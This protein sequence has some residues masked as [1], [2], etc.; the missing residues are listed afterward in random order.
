MIKAVLFDLDGTLLDTSQGIQ[1]S[2]KYTLETLNLP[3]L[4]D[5]MMIKFVGPP[6]QSSLM[7][8]VG[9]SEE[10]AQCGANIF[11]DYYKTEALFEACVYPGII[12]LL[13]HLK[14]HNILVGI[15]T[16]KREDYAIDLLRHFG[17]TQFCDV[18]HG[19]D[20]YNKLTKKD[21]V[22][23]CIKDMCE[24]K[25]DVVLVGDTHFDAEGAQSAGVNFIA[26]TWGFG[27]SCGDVISE[28]PCKAIVNN[29]K[30]LEDIILCCR[31]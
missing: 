7:K 22:E 17:I 27:Y 3:L 12:E 28:Y 9:L 2:V 5:D 8:Y 21:I 13:K 14:Q 6:I 10:Q 25:S 1:S 18:I 26:V 4:S 20:N 24:D 29:V 19:A 31:N 16:Y 11:R 15:A 30:E 23:Q